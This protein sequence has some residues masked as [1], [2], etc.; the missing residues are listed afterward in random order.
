[1]EDVASRESYA[2]A[3]EQLEAY[4]REAEPAAVAAVADG[5]RAVGALLSRQPRLRRALSDP[6][7]TGEDR[8]ALLRGLLEG[9]VSRD[10]VDL[11]VTLVTGRWSSSTGL[12]TAT[13]R[14]AVEALLA[15]AD[16]AGELAEVE[17][18]LFRFGQVVDG[19]TELAATIGDSSVDPGRRAELIR[20]LLEGKANPVTVRLAD[21]A[22]FGYGWSDSSRRPRSGATGRSPTSPWPPRWTRTRSAGWA[23]RCPN[24][25]VGRSTSS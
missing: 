3:A 1:M 7:R 16:R 19:D 11:V 18:E 8:A 14:L 25:T 10:A 13:E 23:P 22:V 9:K 4:A 2:A 20:A 6:A 15:S 5:V 24:C 17:D 21:V 12:L